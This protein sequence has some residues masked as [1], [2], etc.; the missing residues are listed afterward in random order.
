[1]LIERIQEFIDFVKAESP[2]RG[3]N[4]GWIT[5]DVF[6]QL[7][8]AKQQQST[9][10]DQIAKVSLFWQPIIQLALALFAVIAFATFFAFSPLAVSQ[11]KLHFISMY[12][13]SNTD[14]LALNKSLPDVA[15]S[16][17]IPENNLVNIENKKE[18]K[19]IALQ[20]NNSDKFKISTNTIVATK[21]KMITATDLFQPKHN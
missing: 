9:Q 18:N 20:E 6:L 13:Q 17:T 15:I 5:E 10:F 2:H 14:Q 12:F 1:M 8:S 19:A 11:G 4:K 21:K 7:G 3:A 16:S